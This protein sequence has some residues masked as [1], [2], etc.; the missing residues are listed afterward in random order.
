MLGHPVRV[1]RASER[2]WAPLERAWAC[3]PL[4]AWQGMDTPKT[5]EMPTTE[6]Q[7]VVFH[8]IKDDVALPNVLLPITHWRVTLK[9]VDLA[10]RLQHEVEPMV[11]PRRAQV[12]EEFDDDGRYGLRS[13]ELVASDEPVPVAQALPPVVEFYGGYPAG[14]SDPDFDAY[15]HISTMWLLDRD[16]EPSDLLGDPPGLDPDLSLDLME[17]R[18]R[19]RMLEKRATRDPSKGTYRQAD[20][21]IDRL[22]KESDQ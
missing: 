9:H 14:D 18:A 21:F 13:F 11:D 6:P 22:R 19:L 10:G 12:V 8:V 17:A 15:Y 16:E 4:L 1:L 5:V 20:E 2:A 7:I 3:P